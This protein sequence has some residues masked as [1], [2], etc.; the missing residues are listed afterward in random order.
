MQSYRR[1]LLRNR[2]QTDLYQDSKE[3]R[4]GKNSNLVEISQNYWVYA[5]LVSSWVDESAFSYGAKEL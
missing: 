2:G 1:Y 5:E 4:P 3:N